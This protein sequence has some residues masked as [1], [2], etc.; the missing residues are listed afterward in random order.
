MWFTKEGIYYQYSRRIER[1][2]SAAPPPAA[3][4][5]NSKMNL[6]RDSIETMMIKAEHVD[7][8]P[9][10]EIVGVGEQ[11]YKCNYF[12]GKDP[13]NWHT[14]VPNYSA[15]IL[16]GIYPGVDAIFRGKN[17]GI[18]C[19][20]L[21]ASASVL[22]Q[23]K[24]EY[25]GAE[26]ISTQQDGS[27]I[28]KTNLG[29]M[30]FEGVLPVDERA[31]ARKTVTAS[32]TSP[33]GISLAYSTYLGGGSTDFGL[34]IALGSSGNPFVTGGTYSANFPTVN[35]YDGSLSVGPDVFVTKLGTGMTSPVYSTYIGGGSDEYSEDI[36]VDSSGCA[37]LTGRTSSSDFPVYDPYD[38]SFGGGYDA[39]VVKL[40]AAGNSLIYSTYIGGEVDDKGY[41]IAVDDSERVYVTGKTA[42]PDFPTQNPYDGSFNGAED[43]FIVKLSAAGNGLVYATYLGGP[44]YDG[45]QDIAVDRSGCAYVTGFTEYFDFPMPNAY[46]GIRNGID[47]YVVKLSAAGNE[48][49]YGTYL[50]GESM[51]GGTDIVVDSTGSAYV[52][53]ETWSTDFP[54]KNPFDSSHNGHIDLFIARLSAAGN[55]L[56]YSTYFGGSEG[57]EV[58][59]I[60]VSGTGCLYVTGRT[61]SSDLPMHN[62]WDGDLDGD[63]DAFMTKL[64][65]AGN[66][67][68]YST[69]LGGGNSDGGY[70]IAVDRW[71]YAYVTGYTTSPDF[72]VNSYDTRLD[73]SEDAFV[74]E[75]VPLCCEGVRGNVNMTGIVDL[76]DLSALVSYLTGDGYILLCSSEANVNA[77]GIVDLSDL[78][79]LVSYLT[80]GG[81]VLPNCP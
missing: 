3:G 61:Y 60:A 40:S 69:Y 77:T 27:L 36:A 26:S 9:D 76:S 33:E 19:E 63:S 12:I 49:V 37:I 14:D 25:H 54:T 73:G 68:L 81:Y 50:G 10:V 72:P 11:E 47:A 22:A 64:S 17:G 42:S 1:D 28:L 29:E 7:L 6:V 55:E 15:V 62:P 16:K 4:E 32:A 30:R 65:A 71:G 2:E 58:H 31:P 43:A 23:V 34:G 74:T 59:G 48:L 38:G 51:E 35:P 44:I 24:V 18:E 41:G 67:L 45:G 56:V 66:L 13:T 52:A 75:L 5:L 70:G 21:A 57:D 53:G 79:A 20:Y 39:F 80:G 46:D 8:N 78:S